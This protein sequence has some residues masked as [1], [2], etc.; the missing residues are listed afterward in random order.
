MAGICEIKRW[1]REKRVEIKD[2]SAVY[3]MYALKENTYFL[4]SLQLVKA[5]RADFTVGTVYIDGKVQDS[6]KYSFVTV[7]MV[8]GSLA[9]L[10]IDDFKRL[11]A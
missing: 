4:N 1:R 7:Q 8:D 6:N 9:L 10:D 11:Q 3:D 2:G 5:T